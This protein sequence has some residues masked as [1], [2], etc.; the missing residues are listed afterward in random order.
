[1]WTGEPLSYGWIIF[2]RDWLVYWF[3]AGVLVNILVSAFG[4]SIRGA[5]PLLAVLDAVMLSI[6]RV[7]L[8]DLVSGSRVVYQPQEEKDPRWAA[9]QGFI[10]LSILPHSP[11][12]SQPSFL[13]RPSPELCLAQTHTLTPLAGRCGRR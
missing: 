2:V 1:V 4:E 9:R 13:F 10:C 3:V 8:K 7:D 11:C 5:L 12:P 6:W